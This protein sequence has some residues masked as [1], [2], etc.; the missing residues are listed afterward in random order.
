MIDCLSPREEAELRAAIGAGELWPRLVLEAFADGWRLRLG[1]DSALDERDLAA[2][3]GPGADVE[4]S[5][6]AAVR[7]CAARGLHLLSYEADG[8]GEDPMTG[9]RWFMAV[10]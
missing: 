7:W 3:L 2:R 6:R 9:R 10:G 5:L 4:A 1:W 8:P